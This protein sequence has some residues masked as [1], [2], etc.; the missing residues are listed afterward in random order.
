LAS[1]DELEG[2][3]VVVVVKSCTGYAHPGEAVTSS[4]LFV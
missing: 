1:A 3:D 4:Y 2:D